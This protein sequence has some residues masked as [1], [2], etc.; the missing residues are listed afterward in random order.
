[1]VGMVWEKTNS[2]YKCMHVCIWARSL[3]SFCAC[4]RVFA[5]MHALRVVCK[6]TFIMLLNS[7]CLE[8]MLQC[9]T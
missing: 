4:V 6:L 9:E 5:N 7:P 8:C 2:S 3:C 1:V